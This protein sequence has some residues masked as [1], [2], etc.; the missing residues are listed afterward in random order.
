MCCAISSRIR[1]SSGSR[2]ATTSTATSQVDE[3]RDGDYDLAITT[4]DHSLQSAC[5]S[6]PT[7]GSNDGLVVVGGR[8]DVLLA[9]SSSSSL[10]SSALGLS[11]AL[12]PL[13]LQTS[14][15]DASQERE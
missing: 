3:K 15:S 6:S 5:N 1:V 4:K 2:T 14:T 12:P 11:L 9:D 7:F 8:N 10:S 13:S